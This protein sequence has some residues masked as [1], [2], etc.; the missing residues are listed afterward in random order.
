MVGERDN[1][2]RRLSQNLALALL[3]VGEISLIGVGET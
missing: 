2:R 3:G 1:Y